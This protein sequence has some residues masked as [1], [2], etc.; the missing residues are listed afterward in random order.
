MLRD[1]SAAF[2]DAGWCLDRSRPLWHFIEA[3]TQLRKWKVA[4]NLD[5]IFGLI[6]VTVDCYLHL[7]PVV[8]LVSTVDDAVWRWKGRVNDLMGGIDWRQEEIVIVNYYQPHVT[9]SISRNHETAL[10]K[11]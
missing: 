5:V 2:F 6:V 3:S 4:Q 7:S 11:S 10:K 1:T 8:S 9:W